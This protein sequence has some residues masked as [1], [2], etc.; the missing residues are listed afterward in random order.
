[1]AVYHKE[2]HQKKF[3][4]KE[5]VAF[6]LPFCPISPLFCDYCQQEIKGGW[7]KCYHH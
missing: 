5:E 7:K 2:C 4:G 6:P 3:K 1:M